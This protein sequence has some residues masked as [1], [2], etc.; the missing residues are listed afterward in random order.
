MIDCRRPRRPR[1]LWTVALAFGFA[2][3]G[4][5]SLIHAQSRDGFPPNPFWH[6]GKP[7]FESQLLYTS[8]RF[9]NVAVA[10][11]GT[12]VTTWGRN[13]HQVRR[14]EDGGRTWGPLITVSVHD[15]WQNRFPGAGLQGGGLT[16]D[17]NTG[18]IL[19][20]FEDGHPPS[21]R[22]VFRSRDHGRTWSQEAV[23]IHPDSKGNDPSFHM[24][25]RGLTLRY[26]PHAGRLIRPSR[27]YAGSNDREN[28]TN[29][30]TNAMYSDDGGRTWFT[31]EP[32]PAMGTG[33]AAIAELSNGMLYYNSRRH[34][35]T[36]GR[37]P[38][39]RYIAWSDD[40]G[41]TW[42]DL[43][44]SDVLPD[45]AQHVDYGLMA[46]LVRLPVDGHDILLFSNIDVPD[47][48]EEEE[49]PHHLR[50]TRR[51]RGTIWVSFDG[52]RTWPL[53]R[54]VYGGDFGYS[55]LAAGRPGTPS[56]GFIYLFY[57]SK[58]DASLARFD[59]GH[60]ARF[61]LAWLTGGQDWRDFLPES[62]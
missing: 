11:D 20:F 46:G 10:M 6:G 42:G 36:D 40:G 34:I 4:L 23:V 13:S 62:E 26:G 25:E 28:W 30:Y 24:N 39:M 47:T 33:E 29:H 38:R 54:L 55:S 49:I 51:E 21:D 2:L 9:P 50:T 37:N 22:L 16:V 52:G 1:C 48:G 8:E 12:I 41:H 45:G 5:G 61:N 15:W 14:S 53:Q 59:Q 56:E 19:T 43:S 18:D 35:S 32:F 3:P 17:E 58:S 44:V 31:S 60:I 57:E 27:S 7:F